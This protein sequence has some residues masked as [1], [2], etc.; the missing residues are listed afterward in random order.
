MITRRHVPASF[1]IV[2]IAFAGGCRADRSSPSWTVPSNP[3]AEPAMNWPQTTEGLITFVQNAA[4]QLHARGTAAFDDFAR[5]GSVWNH[6]DNY[7]FISDDRTGRI[8]FHGTNAQ[9][10]GNVMSELVG[11][12]GRKFG[13]FASDTLEFSDHVWAFYN[14]P[15]P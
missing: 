8:I 13:K 14:W 2:L 11:E 7:L 5:K 4:T 12:E 10:V 1:G 3:P 9:I 6:D 15:R